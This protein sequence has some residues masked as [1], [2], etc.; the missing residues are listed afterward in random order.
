[1]PFSDDDLESFYREIEARTASRDQPRRSHRGGIDYPACPTPDKL[2]FASPADA[3]DGIDRLRRHIIGNAPDLRY[4][5]CSCGA[6]HITSSAQ[7]IHRRVPPPS[8]RRRKGKKK[9]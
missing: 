5:E 3:R 1:M 2:P 9:R 6:W 4:Y 7:L 8:V